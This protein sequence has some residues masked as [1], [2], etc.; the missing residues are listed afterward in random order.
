MKLYSL[1]NNNSQLFNP[2]FVALDDSDAKEVTR[3]AII[4]ARDLTLLTELD[5]IELYHVG[6]FDVDNGFL[7]PYD[8]EL[9]IAQKAA[10]D[11]AFDDVV[12]QLGSIRKV[13]NLTDLKL[14][15]HIQKA[16]D[17]LRNLSVGKPEDY[18]K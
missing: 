8:H 2:P 18:E 12:E 1:K 4:S 16:V 15:A 7:I 13:C 11:P 3:K 10:N 5:S 17:D 14:P 9:K 6:D